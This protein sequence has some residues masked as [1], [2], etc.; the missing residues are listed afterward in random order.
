[1]T[2]ISSTAAVSISDRRTTFSQLGPELAAEVCQH[3][4]LQSI[5]SILESR[6]ASKQLRLYMAKTLTLEN[7]MFWDEVEKLR[8]LRK[9]QRQRIVDR[10]VLETSPNQVNLDMLCR[11]HIETAMEKE[12]GGGTANSLYRRVP[13]MFD[14]AQ[15][16]IV[17]LMQ[18]NTYYP[19]LRSQN[20]QQFIKGKQRR[21]R[22][23]ALE[24]EKKARV[25]IA[26]QTVSASPVRPSVPSGA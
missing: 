18:V 22:R 14:E 15:R 20:C 3:R 1:M 26:T 23:R 10:F 12:Q 24:E 16:E 25:L 9:A 5:E 17:E 21:I 2:S 19:F 7:F 13:T 4:E 6:A 11:Q 8:A